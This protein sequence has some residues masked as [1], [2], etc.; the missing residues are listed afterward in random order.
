MVFSLVWFY[1]ISTIVGYLMP[2]SFYTFMLNIMICLHILEKTLDEP[3]L[4]FA[5]SQMTSS[6]SI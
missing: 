5:H 6:I 3:E 2:N 4:F 1:G